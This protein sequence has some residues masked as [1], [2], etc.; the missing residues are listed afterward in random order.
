MRVYYSDHFEVCL[1]PENRFPMAKYALLRHR[2]VAERVLAESELVPAEPAPLD[3]LT[4][5]HD[6]DYV[7]AIVEGT[8]APKAMAQI[9]FP[10]SPALVQRSIAS[11]GATL[12]AVEAALVDGFSGALGGGTHHARSASGA[13]F[14]VFNDLAV[15]TSSLLLSD[16]ARCVLIIDLD[17][18]QGDGTADIFMDDERVYTF[19]MHGAKNFPGRKRLSSLDVEFEDDTGD[20]EYLRLLEYHLPE[21]LDDPDIDFILYQGG[22][23]PLAEDRF[24]RLALTHSGLRA[25]DRIVF[26]AARKLKVPIV[27]TLGGGYAEP[28]E[29]SIQAHVNTYRMAREVFPRA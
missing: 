5:V 8:I 22:V 28:I 19:S 2:L 16:R 4:L 10:W 21:A 9:G 18:H 7:R 24:G 25:R 13:G 17:V 15:A 3:A 11:V 23:D 1:P 29:L 27:A 26:R 20:E 6:P 12:A 14:C